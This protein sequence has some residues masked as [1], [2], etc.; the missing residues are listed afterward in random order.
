[1]KVS[2]ESPP[3]IGPAADAATQEATRRSRPRPGR[4]R[5]R[6]RRG[7]LPGTSRRAGTRCSSAPPTPRGAHYA[8]RTGTLAAGGP[9]KTRALL[10]REPIG[11]HRH[12]IRTPLD[13][14]VQLILGRAV[15][16]IMIMRIMI[17]ITTITTTATITTIT[18]C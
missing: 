2:Q 1:M 4:P 11:S 16:A 9:G 17:I 5:F 15:H 13:L 8:S 10:R 7:R 14:A 3:S 12:P 18:Q 6:P